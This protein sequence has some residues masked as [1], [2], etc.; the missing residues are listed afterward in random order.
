MPS[1]FFT[2]KMSLENRIEIWIWKVRGD[3]VE[4]CNTEILHHRILFRVWK[5]FVR[6]KQKNLATT[7]VPHSE[8]VYV[9]SSF[10]LLRHGT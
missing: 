4:V 3:R 8:V 7:Q 2:I 1:H 5:S 10:S 9:I 6:I